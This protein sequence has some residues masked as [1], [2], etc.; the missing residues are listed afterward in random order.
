MYYPIE[1]V[2]DATSV[3]QANIR[4]LGLVC[5][6]VGRPAWPD[7][8]VPDYA[9]LS[10]ALWGILKEMGFK[11]EKILPMVSYF[12][13]PL[14]RLGDE[15]AV[16]AMGRPMK[17]ALYQ[18]C[19][20]RYVKVIEATDNSGIT[21]DITTGSAA[22]RFPSPVLIL[23]VALPKLYWLAVSALRLPPG[24]R[25]LEEAVPSDPTFPPI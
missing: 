19:D 17:V 13:D 8:Q 10:I 21:Y 20:N 3:D 24:Q 2:V 12:L 4:S 25:V 14:L 1:R 16:T 9:V 18:V 22:K 23:S 6:A 15:Y 11:P 5:K 7:D